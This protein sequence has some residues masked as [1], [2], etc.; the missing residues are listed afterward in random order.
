MQKVAFVN[1]PNEEQITR[2]YMCSYVSPES[3]FP[4]LELISLAAVARQWHQAQVLLIDCIAER[5]DMTELTGK[6]NE[7]SPDIIVSLTGF[8]CIE[9]DVE[10]VSRIKRALPQATYVLFGHYATM[11]PDEILTMSMADIVIAG[12]PELIF[13][14]LINTITEGS[15]IDK[16]EGIVFY[17]ADQLI[18]TGNGNRIRNP[19]DLPIPAYDLLPSNAYY[20]PLLPRP[21]GMIQ[22]AR[23]CPYQCNFCVKSYGGLLTELTPERIIEEMELWVKLHGVRVIRFIDDTFT[24][25]RKRVT[26]ICQLITERRLKVAWACLSRTDNLDEELLCEMKSAGCIRIY[27]GVESGSQQMLDG[28]DKRMN[29]QQARK[30]LIICR[31]LG[32]ETAG[33]FMGGHPDETEEQFSDT[34]KFVASSG[35]NFA[36]YNPLTPYPGTPLFEKMKEQLDFSLFPYR[37]QWKDQ[38]IYETFDKRKTRF[39]RT[40]YLR[41]SLVIQ[42]LTVVGRNLRSATGLVLGLFRYLFFDRKFVISGLKGRHDN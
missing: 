30:T 26:R 8:E 33:F 1:L 19:N 41:P 36:S 23:G 42:N 22:T 11:F 34:L 18:R 39:Y 3:L 15:S 4:P 35:L 12:E 28:Y 20:E 32:I 2:R 29:V 13:S 31:K 5:P 9:S 17:Q 7:F 38:G 21:Y 10:L 24:I 16:V 27:F 6:L 37:N 40:F 25:N 14:S